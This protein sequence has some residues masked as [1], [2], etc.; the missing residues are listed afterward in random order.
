[1][2]STT[3]PAASN[4]EPSTCGWCRR[5]INA[6]MWKRVHLNILLIQWST[7]VSPPQKSVFSSTSN[8]VILCTDILRVCLWEN[9]SD[10]SY[11]TLLQNI[12]VVFISPYNMQIPR[13][14]RLQMNYLHLIGLIFLLKHQLSK[15]AAVNKKVAQIG[16]R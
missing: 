11:S 16:R 3:F 2:W 1:M 5:P 8:L 15:K 9:I 7:C 12:T 4:K 14:Y 10:Q 13:K 6:I